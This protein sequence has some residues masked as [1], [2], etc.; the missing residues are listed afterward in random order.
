MSP[1]Y[2]YLVIAIVCV[3]LALVYVAN[4]VDWEDVLTPRAT[5]PVHLNGKIDK[6]KAL[7][8]VRL[9]NIPE[10]VY[11]SIKWG[12]TKYTRYVTGNQKYVLVVSFGGVPRLDT[13]KPALRQ[14][15]HEKGYS[16]YYRR[17]IFDFTTG[18]SWRCDRME[19]AEQWIDE[20]CKKSV[21]II[22]PL[23]KQAIIDSS[24]DVKQLE[25]LLEKYKEW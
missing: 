22:H 1:K 19:C 20:H 4:Q 12:D 18:Y 8:Q 14:L 7:A 21:C 5:Q 6:T 25:S 3:V 15:L 16:Q 2:N 13:F 9:E 10:T 24:A 17:H 23:K 11:E